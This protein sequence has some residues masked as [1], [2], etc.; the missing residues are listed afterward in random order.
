MLK[1]KKISETYDMK[2]FTDSG[3]YFGGG[4]CSAIDWTCAGGLLTSTDT[5]GDDTCGGTADSPT[6]T[7]YTCGASDGAV[8]DTCQ[9]D[10]TEESDICTDTGSPLGGGMCSA[11]DWTCTDGVLSRTSSEGMD[12]CGGTA[13]NPNVTYYTCSASDG[14]V[15]D[16]CQTNVTARSDTCVDDG[17]ILGGGSCNAVDWTCNAGMLNAF[18]SGGIDICGGSADN[19]N[20]TYYTCSA[21]D[22][23]VVDICETD[24]TERYDSC[25]DDGTPYGGGACSANDW[26]CYNGVLTNT[27]TSGTDTCGGTTENPF[28]SYF[29]CSSYDGT[30]E[31]ACVYSE[32]AIEPV[33]CGIGECQRTVQA[34]ENGQAV[35]CV[36]GEP[37]AEVCDGFDNDCDGT[38]DEGLVGE[39]C[40]YPLSVVERNK[41]PP[42]GLMMTLRSFCI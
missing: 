40:P 2:V 42:A 6:I 18:H 5:G 8:E 34:C 13:D 39:P 32:T 7:Y 31:D 4:S 19:P 10:V 38:V 20:V 9:A 28:V 22:G 16:I 11:V 24:L 37:S 21:S 15:A 23:S 41:I 35:E 17:S 12:S 33:T 36:P 27:E 25:T 14:A 3:D 29:Y 26:D 30:T 1:M